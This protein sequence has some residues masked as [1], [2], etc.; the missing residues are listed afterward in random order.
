MDTAERRNF[1]LSGYEHCSETDLQAQFV[2]GSNYRPKIGKD[3][4]NEVLEEF[5][6]LEKEVGSLQDLLATSEELLSE[7]QDR[8]VQLEDKLAEER[9]R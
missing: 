6:K 9:D 8:I 5:S 7:K 4:L 2:D 3:S 1:I